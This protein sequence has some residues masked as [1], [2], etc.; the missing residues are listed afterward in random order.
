MADNWKSYF[1]TVNWKLA[2]VRTNLGLRDSLQSATKPWLLWVWVYFQSPR[3]DGLSASEEAPKLFEIEDALAS[4]I[5][6]SCDAVICGVITT[7]GRR[8]F[9]FYAENSDPFE[10][11]VSEV[12][13]LFAGYKYDLGSQED[14]FWSQY[15]N[16]LYPSE[17]Q[18]ERIANRD[19]LDHLLEQ[20][21]NPTIE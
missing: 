14:P 16:V 10:S 4:A 1:C 17:E 9:Y 8:E 5:A 7:E 21:D 3:A 13:R 18:L 11:V 19:L 2:S 12:V 6:R 15:L 20:G